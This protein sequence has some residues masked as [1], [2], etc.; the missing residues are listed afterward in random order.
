MIIAPA[1]FWPSGPK[2]EEAPWRSPRIRDENFAVVEKSRFFKNRAR[3]GLPKL[4][5]GSNESTAFCTQSATV[6]T[7]GSTES[8]NE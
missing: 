7:R 1:G 6:V 8:L 3:K 5:W 2:A 4:R